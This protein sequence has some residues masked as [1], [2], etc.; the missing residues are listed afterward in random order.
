M[1]R[2]YLA[3][4]H[5]AHVLVLACFGCTTGTDDTY[6]QAIGAAADS[7]AV[8]FDGVPVHFDQRGTGEPVLLFVHGWANTGSVWDAQMTHFSERHRVIAVDLPGFGKSGHG[9]AEWTIEAFGEDVAAVVR[10]LGLERVVLIGFSLGASVVVEAVTKVPEAV[11][12]VVLVDDLKDPEMTYPT[13]IVAFM[14]SVLMDLVT[15]PSSEKLV[16]GGFYRMN[17]EASYERVLA[18][19]SSHRNE[20][21][22]GWRE[23]IGGYFRWLNEDCIESLEAIR[24]PIVSFVSDAEPVNADGF[25]R[26]VSAYRAEV[27]P[28]A[29]HL[30]MWDAP[31]EF[32]RLLEESVAEFDSLA[33]GR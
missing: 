25:R 12:G 29:G 31:A 32:N 27:I 20:A 33:Q 2:T 23:T 22:I 14:D 15:T 24:A 3:A 18:M 4:R 17:P 11:I 21:R 10:E 28:N 1:K 8:S 9:R 7:I 30:L 6:V 19:L 26:H 16:G 13:E 5:I